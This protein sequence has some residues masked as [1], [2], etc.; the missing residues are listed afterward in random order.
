MHS[1]INLLREQSFFNLFREDALA[2]DLDERSFAQLVARSLD[3]F[4]GDGQSGVNSFE[5]ALDPIGLP[6]G[7]SAA[8][9]ADNQIW[10]IGISPRK[11]IEA[12]QV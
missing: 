8:A 4:N 9:R 12:R 10:H 5:L 2:A 3:D 6:Q 11:V 1:Q 7:E